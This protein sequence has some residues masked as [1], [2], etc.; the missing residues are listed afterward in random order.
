MSDL[1][2]DTSLSGD[3]SVSAEAWAAYDLTSSLNG[4]SSVQADLLDTLSST[5]F[6][7]GDSSLSGTPSVG[8][9][10]NASL[11]GD[12]STVAGAD[13]ITLLTSALMA[14][15]TI[16]ANPVA[17]YAGSFTGLGA[18]SLASDL[19]VIQG[20]PAPVRYVPPCRTVASGRMILDQ[21]DLFL[22][23]GK[24]RAQGVRISDLQL[25]VFL[26]GAQVDWP[27]VSGSGVQDPRVTA[28]KV[29]W[30]EFSSGFYNLRFFP[31][32]LGNWRV[33]ITYP[34]HDQASSFTY[35]V[36]QQVSPPPGSGMR[37][38]FIR[39]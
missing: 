15:S 26:N 28:G 16:T 23:D 8:Y 3:S 39:R 4:D 19:T 6:L 1:D 37:T 25:R 22:G 21:V 12:S 38:S 31:N 11:S 35:D 9:A 17:S 20:Y 34:T 24:T 30:T 18:S 7:A 32:Q 33:I 13:V 36:V 5:A 10:L 27:L 14:D 29:Y 2:L